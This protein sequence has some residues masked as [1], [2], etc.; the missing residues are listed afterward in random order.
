MQEIREL[1]ALFP[2]QPPASSS[3]TALAL[4]ERER[5]LEIEG[6]DATR[7]LQGQLSCDV[8]TL[9][10]GGNTL[11][12]RCN[13][14]G[15]MQSSFRLLK[16]SEERYLLAMDAELLELQQSDL[17]KYAAFFK[18]QLSDSTDQWVRLGLWGSHIE[19]ALAAASLSREASTP[20]AG[21]V[22]DLD[23]TTVELWLPASRAQELATTLA[24][25]AEPVAF[26]AWQLQQI[27][28]GIGQV[29]SQTRESFIP[30][31][32]NLQQLGGVSFQKGCYTG[33]EIVAR[34]QYLGKLK[35]RMYRLTRAGVELPAPGT[36]ILNSANDQAVGEV[37]VAASAEDRMELLAV[38]QNEA[39][40]LPTLHIGDSTRPLQLATLPYED[41]MAA[42]AAGE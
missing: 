15:R 23:D 20:D 25:H 14:K 33:Q 13:P 34:M 38:L 42:D 17:A 2:Q 37:V 6:S 28:L 26:N 36:P 39:A 32:L 5:I 3:A 10:S 7:F 8:A 22:I 40:Q 16:L 12:S 4:L 1:S 30:Q 11:G 41:Q 18:V 19:E 27:R 21:Q 31:M 24:Q 9:P 35:R 29:H